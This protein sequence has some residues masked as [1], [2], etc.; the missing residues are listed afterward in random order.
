VKI[1]CV[2]DQIDPLVYTPSIRERFKD[3][4]LALCA[5]DLPLDYLEYIVSMLDKPLYFVF[6]NHDLKEFRR[7]K[8]TSSDHYHPDRFDEINSP[9]PGGGATWIGGKTAQDGGL[10]IAGLGG[11]MRYNNG[12]NQFTEAQMRREIAKLYPRLLMNK[13]RYGRWLDILLTHA[14]PRGLGDRDDPCHLG[15]NAFLWFMRKFRPR[16]LIHGH[17]HLYDIAAQ[18]T[19]QYEDT[20]II[21]VFGHYVLDIDL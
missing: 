2:A 6:G 8:P 4:D 13:L 5:G 16:Y 19:H 15:F 7:Y 17:I 3:C 20:T 21:N 9:M 14:A 1:L 11:S 10:L 18:R 12:E